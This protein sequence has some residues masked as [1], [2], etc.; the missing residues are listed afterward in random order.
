M[1]YRFALAQVSVKV[2][3]LL[4]NCKQ[5]T[6]SLSLLA[7]RTV[8]WHINDLLVYHLD[9]CLCRFNTYYQKRQIVTFKGILWQMEQPWQLG[10]VL[11]LFTCH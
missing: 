2:N 3:I 8:G 1:S 4:N 10:L 9:E 11:I 5:N 7:G 6:T